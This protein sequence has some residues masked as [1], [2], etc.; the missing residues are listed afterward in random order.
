MQSIRLLDVYLPP[1]YDGD[2]TEIRYPV[3]YYLHGGMADETSNPELITTLD[4]LI[5]D[6]EIEPVIV[7][8]PNGNCAVYGGLS[9]YTTSEVNGDYETWLTQELPTYIE[10]SFNAS[11]DAAKRSIMGFSMGGFGAVMLALKYPDV[12]AAVASHSGALDLHAYLARYIPSVLQEN[13]GSG[14]YSPDAGLYTRFMFGCS[15]AWS[16]NPTAEPEPVDFPLDNEGNPI[17]E[18]IARWNLH[19]PAELV[20][21]YPEGG[22]PSLYFDCGTSDGMFTMSE[23]FED[24]LVALGLP[25]HY[26][27]Y[28]GNHTSL[29][30]RFPISLAYLD[31]LMHPV[32]DAV[33]HSGDDDLPRPF[34]V[35][36]CHPN[37]FNAMTRV[38]VELDH[39]QTV[40]MELF[41]VLGRSVAVMTDGWLQQGKSEFLLDGHQLASGVY[42]LRTNCGREVVDLQR[43]VLLR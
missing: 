6:G 9:W 11:T 18:V 21:Q 33:P 14:P 24:T 41:D 5:A 20:H 12:Y 13:G 32:E 10:S 34:H 28:P 23:A 2:D 7:A 25:Y 1:G 22:Y 26:E 39:A 36:P 15:A 17:P 8:K 3:I 30:Q 19:N 16:P 42:L 40:R 4:A 31:S 37:P 27:T 35:Q 38:C 43:V 29:P